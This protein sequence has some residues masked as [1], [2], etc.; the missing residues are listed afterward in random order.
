LTAGIDGRPMDEFMMISRISKHFGK[1][2]S[3]L[4]LIGPLMA[5]ALL[6]CA[7]SPR[8]DNYVNWKGGFWF[9]VPDH[10]EQVD[11]AIVDRY[12][13]MMDTSRDIFN[14]EAVFAPATSRV[15]SQDAYLV[16]TFDSLG[17]LTPKEIDSVLTTIAETYSTVVEEAPIVNYM[18]DLKPGVPQVDRSKNAVTVI[19]EMA[20]QPESMR[21]LWLYMRL[22]DRG[23]ISLY[24]YSPDSTFKK[25]MPTFEE[26]VNSLSF[27]GLKEASAEELTFT[28]V[29]TESTGITSEPPALGGE[30]KSAG[31]GNWIPYV[32]LALIVLYLI[33]RFALAP[34]T[35]KRK[36][37]SV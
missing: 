29:G 6:F 2:K 15:F 30:A 24:F 3:I 9:A 31:S 28:Q 1:R 36:K 10:W 17:K 4:A 11:Y 22:N 37:D 7:A 14:Y 27:T 25:N 8:A 16:V 32:A 35:R 23:L 5:L 13:S 26:I 34:R 18:S 33:W 20:Y 12:L 19:S 21:K